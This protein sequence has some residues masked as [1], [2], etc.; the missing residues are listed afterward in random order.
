[1]AATVQQSELHPGYTVLRLN[2]R[3]DTTISDEVEAILNDLYSSGKYDIIID[4]KESNYLSSMGLRVLFS[5]SRLLEEKNKKLTI[6]NA[7]PTVMKVIRIA[8]CA[9]LF[10]IYPT[11][12]DMK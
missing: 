7:G 3:F 8:D 11:E 10:N 6:V 2:K 9:S 1:M 12:E 5:A 4:F